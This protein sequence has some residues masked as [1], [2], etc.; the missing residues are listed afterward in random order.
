MTPYEQNVV[1]A[2]KDA[3]KTNSQR[4]GKKVGASPADVTHLLADRKQI[5]D[6]DTV[7]DI[8]EIMQKLRSWGRL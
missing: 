4:E 7:L 1:A 6:M 2:F 8:E 3:C 5:S